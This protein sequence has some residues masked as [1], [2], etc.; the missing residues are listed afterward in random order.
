MGNFPSAI[1]IG[2]NFQVQLSLVEIFQVQLS[3][4][5]IFKELMIQLSQDGNIIVLQWS[6]Y[7][8]H[9]YGSL[10]DSL[11]MH[12]YNF[13]AHFLRLIPRSIILWYSESYKYHFIWY[14]HAI[15][16]RQQKG[17]IRSKC[18]IGGR[19]RLPNVF[20]VLQTLHHS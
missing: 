20:L 13:F 1:I 2:W 4:V 17:F 7:I 16:T 18:L 10:E 12:P 9:I 11:D 8:A 5:E 3:L 14:V 6:W 15:S 19:N